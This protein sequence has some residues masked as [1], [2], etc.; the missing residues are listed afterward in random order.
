M[1][2]KSILQTHKIIKHYSYDLLCVRYMYV[3]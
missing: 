1:N 3:R 2:A